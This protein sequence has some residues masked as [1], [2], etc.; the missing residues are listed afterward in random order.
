MD[1]TPLEQLRAI[2]QEE[3]DKRETISGFYNRKSQKRLDIIKEKIKEIGNTFCKM[4]DDLTELE[5]LAPGA[6]IPEN[7]LKYPIIYGNNNPVAITTNIE[8]D[9]KNENASFFANRDGKVNL[10][11]A[12]SISIET[13]SKE[14]SVFGFNIPSAKSSVLLLGVYNSYVYVGTDKHIRPQVCTADI[15]AN[16]EALWQKLIDN[17]DKVVDNFY[18]GYNMECKKQIANTQKVIAEL[19]NEIE[20]CER[21]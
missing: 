10:A 18:Y 11:S 6:K 4:R 17:W 13:D 7:Y 9:L 19:D 5:S 3:N 21:E 16:T 1:L 20:E 2:K 15:D 12:L 14:P 8:L